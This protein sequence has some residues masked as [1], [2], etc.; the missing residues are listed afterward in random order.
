MQKLIISILLNLILIGFSF[1]ETESS[2]PEIPS[3]F[4]DSELDDFLRQSFQLMKESAEQGDAVAQL[5]VAL[6]Y[7]HGRG[8]QQDLNQAFEWIKKSAEQGNAEAQYNLSVMYRNGEGVEQDQEKALYWLKKAAQQ[9]HIQ[10]QDVLISVEFTE[11][12]SP[13]PE[14]PLQVENAEQAIWKIY[15]LYKWRISGTGFFIGPNHFI[16][17]FHVVFTMLNF[18]NHESEN[19]GTIN[20]IVLRQKEN[21][22]VL[23]VKKILAVSVLYD[24]VL[25]ETEENVT[26]YLS[27]REHPP[28]ASENLFSIGYPGGT[29]KKIRKTGNIVYE[30]DHHYSFP[31]DHHGSGGDSGS[32]VLDE[33]GL[34]TG[35][36]FRASLNTMHVIKM[37][38]LR[39]FIKGNIGINCAQSF[40]V[41][42]KLLNNYVFNNFNKRCIEKDIENL[43]EL[44]EKGSTYAQTMLA[45]IYNTDYWPGWWDVGKAAQWYVRAAQQGYAIAQFYLSNLY[46]AQQHL[47][48]A[49]LWA[50]AAAEQGY[51]GAQY[52]LAQMYR[53]GEGTPENLNQAILWYEKAAQ[54]GDIEAQYNLAQIYRIGMGVEQNQ[55]KALYWMKKAADQGYIQVQD[56]LR[57]IE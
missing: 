27:L 50:Q 8:T 42:T 44:A 56:V 20:Y 53:K 2:F 48:Q 46:G 35:V 52:N 49:F 1:A 21:S 17:G 10:A 18:Q 36:L 32:P 4:D 12:E 29:F 13:F 3:Q 57:T 25:L 55:E 39:E 28:E 19:H 5:H 16:T 22:S 7:Q 24:L 37:N 15:D 43:E 23:K 33:Q 34:V 51:S 54:Q 11:T 47:K 30:D 26:N 31:T 38:H 9:G 6:M 14:I 41:M 40:G 45:H